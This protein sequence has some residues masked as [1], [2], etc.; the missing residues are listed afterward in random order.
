MEEKLNYVCRKNKF[1]I[2]EPVVSERTAGGILKTDQ[3][4][5]NEAKEYSGTA[6]KIIKIGKDLEDEGFKEGDY[7]FINGGGGMIGV[8]VDGKKYLSFEGYCIEGKVEDNILYEKKMKELKDKIERG[9][10]SEEQRKKFIPPI[11]IGG[12][13]KKILHKTN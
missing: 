10:E 12:N 7:V 5:Q 6:H 13:N 8:Q 11:P 4:I 3:Q 2:A 1:L 9:I